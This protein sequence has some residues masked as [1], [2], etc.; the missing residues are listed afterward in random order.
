MGPIETK[1]STFVKWWLLEF[2][3]YFIFITCGIKL[4]MLFLCLGRIWRG[5]GEYGRVGFYGSFVR[6]WRGK[7][8]RCKISMW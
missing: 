8:G 4:F 3:F 7:C 1:K 5:R 2:Y 6:E